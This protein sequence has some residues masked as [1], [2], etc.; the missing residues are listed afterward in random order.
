MNENDRINFSKYCDGFSESF[1]GLRFTLSNLAIC[2]T[3]HRE[4]K[5]ECA[6]RPT[7]ARTNCSGDTKCRAEHDVARAI[8][9]SVARGRGRASQD[10]DG[11]PAGGEDG[12]GGGG[13]RATGTY[14]APHR[15]RRLHELRRLD[16]Q[17]RVPLRRL[18]A[19]HRR[20]LRAGMR[21]PQ[22]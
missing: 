9:E 6:Q 3:K 12:A 14:S 20:S 1:D 19:R 10:A 8:R 16:R 18:P 5:I 7:G 4:N 11:E 21:R 13:L 22:A 2:N 15:Q 17:R